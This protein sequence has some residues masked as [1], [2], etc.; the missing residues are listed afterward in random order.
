MKKDNSMVQMAFEYA[1]YMMASSYFAQKPACR[2]EWMEGKLYFHYQMMKE[3]DQYQLEDACIRYLEQ[4]LKDVVPEELW[5]ADR[6]EAKLI[7][8][9]GAKY[10][11]LLFRSRDFALQLM[12]R[13][14]SASR[15][16]EFKY[17]ISSRKKRACYPDSTAS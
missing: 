13:Y 4:D 5:L 2:S 16:A 11:E 15:K 6:V 14:D 7:R 8:R 10:T 1:L 12:G 9:G 3:R 17:C